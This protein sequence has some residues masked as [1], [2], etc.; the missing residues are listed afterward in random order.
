MITL[1]SIAENLS[2]E[3]TRAGIHER[4]NENACDF[5]SRIYEHFFEILNKNQKSID[6]E[7]LN[8]FRHVHIADSSSW[9]IP[10]A[11]KRFFPG[12][13]DAGCKTQFIIDYKTGMIQH[14]GITKQTC[15]DQKYSQNIADLIHK[16][17][18]SIFD[19][20]Y[21]L[22]KNL[23]TIDDKKGFFVCR[24]NTGNMNVYLKENQENTKFQ[25]LKFLKKFSDCDSIVEIPCYVGKLDQMTKVR[26]LAIRVPEEAANERRRKK[27]RQTQKQGYTPTRES[28]QLCNWTLLITNTPKEKLNVREIIALYSIRWT[29]ELFFKQLKSI[30][31]IHKSEV[32]SNP[33][34]LKCEIL[35]RCI[36]AMFIAYCYS[37]CNALTWRKLGCEI[38]FEKTVKYFKRNIAA[39]LDHLFTSIRKSIRYLNVMLA[40]IIETCQ[41]YRQRTRKNS[42]DLLVDRSI[43]KHLKHVK[44]SHTKIVAMIA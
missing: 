27:R 22:T 21:V 28:L 11:L 30:L 16:D 24:L 20:A 44:I 43:Y 12:Y 23:K 13:V 14:L 6:V 7:V 5:L 40:K 26:L 15:N 42:L 36:A 39:L 8:Q 10:K 31:K 41:K 38:S 35:G 34:R 29:I 9:K 3:I 37:I 19:L 17:D 4:F 18:L 2:T 33:H 1:A 25:L 32:K